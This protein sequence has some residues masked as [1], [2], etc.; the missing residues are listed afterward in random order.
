MTLFSSIYLELVWQ[1]WVEAEQSQKIRE[2]S[3]VIEESKQSERMTDCHWHTVLEL[4]KERPQITGHNH[5]LPVGNCGLS[6]RLFPW[7]GLSSLGVA[8]RWWDCFF[9]PPDPLSSPGSSVC[10]CIPMGLRDMWAQ[11][12]TMENANSGVSGITVIWP[13]N[14]YTH[15]PLIWEFSFTHTSE[16]ALSLALTHILLKTLSFHKTTQI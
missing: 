12:L 13:N 6:V 11:G 3:T 8:I 9:S 5:T 16:K 15:T 14:H 7:R 4:V 10:E 2:D 1:L